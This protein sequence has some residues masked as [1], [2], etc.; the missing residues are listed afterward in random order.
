MHL[1]ESSLQTTN[2]K[3]CR[4]QAFSLAIDKFPFLPSLLSFVVLF[5]ERHGTATGPTG[6]TV[7]LW[8]GTQTAVPVLCLASSFLPFFFSFFPI[9]PLGARLWQPRR[10]RGR[11]RGR[12]AALCCGRGWPWAPCAGASDGAWRSGAARAARSAVR[13]VSFLLLLL[14][15]VLVLLLCVE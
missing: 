1:K 15:L 4:E 8:P 3:Y 10:A 9:H 14:L 5:R 13:L 12:G 11:R 2:E 6:L 7:T